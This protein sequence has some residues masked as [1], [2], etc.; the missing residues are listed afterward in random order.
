MSALVALLLLWGL[1]LGPAAEGAVFFKTQPSL[2]ADSKSLLE[3]WADMTLTCQARLETLDFQLFKDGVVQKLVHLDI[4]DMEYQFPLGAVTN[5]N[6]GLYRCRSGLS[7]GTWTELSN[8]LEVTG[9][10]TLPPPLLSVEPV[11]WIIPGLNVTLLCHGG[12]RGVSFLLRREGDDEFLEVA[13]TRKEGVASFP[14]HQAGN[15]SC[16]YQ[17]HAAGGPS[18]P[19]ATV[20]IE[21]VAV[22]PPPVLTSWGQ[23]PKILGPGN[24]VGLICVAPLGGA[25]FGLW[26]LEGSVHKELQVPM[27]STSPDRVF[28]DLDTEALG[29]GGP[30]ICRYRLRGK[31][32]VWSEDSEPTELVRSD[33]S[34][35]AP[36]LTA[37]PAGPRIAPGSLVELRCAAPG[38]GKRFALQ[39]EDPGGRRLL[40]VRRPGRPHAVFQLRDVSAADSANYSCVYVDL[41]PPFAGSAPSAPVELRVDG[42]P[43]QPQLRALW[44]RPVRAGRD[45]FLRCEGRVPDVVFELLRGAEAEPVVTLSAARDSQSADL[46]LTFVGPQ[47]TGNYSCRYRAQWPA[48]FVSEPSDPVELLVAGS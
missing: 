40:A 43:P 46:A 1:T 15:Y 25:E 44:T 11:S 27:S 33:E 42:P 7:S 8:L 48:D 38:G 41:A 13:E 20:T 35:P 28:F 26:R 34:L 31:D 29:D 24:R 21:E 16:S 6:R 2:W 23:Y 47:H 45:A 17:T 39:R 30:F 9:T 37:E 12:L 22:L 10:E 19:S 32:T 4:P 18:E 36:V 3:P 14:V 5:D